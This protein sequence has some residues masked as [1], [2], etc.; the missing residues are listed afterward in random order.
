MLHF[1]NVCFSL[2]LS[3]TFD[4]V[5]RVCGHLVRWIVVGTLIIRKKK[6][7]YPPPPYL[8]PISSSSRVYVE[9]LESWLR[10]GVFCEYFEPVK[11]LL[12]SAMT[13]TYH[14]VEKKFWRIPALLLLLIASHRAVLLSCW[15]HAFSIP[16]EHSR[17]IE[18]F[19]LEN[20]QFAP[21][22][23]FSTT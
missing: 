4:C 23:V 19:H 10:R 5:V 16:F 15:T 22:L 1:E 14:S 6:K 21:R 18:I 9:V 8:F 13:F 3:L 12:Y 11:I 20:F 17:V 7:I 2:S